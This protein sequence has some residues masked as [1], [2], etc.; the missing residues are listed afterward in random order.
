MSTTQM[1]P[2]IPYPSSS[3][4][5]QQAHKTQYKNQKAI[6]YASAPAPAPAPTILISV[7]HILFFTPPPIH[8]SILPK[9]TFIRERVPSH[10]V[11]NHPPPRYIEQSTKK[12]FSPFFTFLCDANLNRLLE[13]FFSHAPYPCPEVDPITLFSRYFHF[14]S[15]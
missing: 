14:L 7:R 12:T 13:T 6:H 1:T 10:T 11:A 8:H 4:S 9:R 3:S 2:S 15:L 5:P